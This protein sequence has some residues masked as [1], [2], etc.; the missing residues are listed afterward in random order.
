MFLLTDVD[1]LYTADPRKD[2]T[3]KPIHL[4][5]NLEELQADVGAIGANGTVTPQST[6]H[7]SLRFAIDR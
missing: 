2:P 7:G 4:V 1:A 5:E 6:I 3:A